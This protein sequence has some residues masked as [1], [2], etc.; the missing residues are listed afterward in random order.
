MRFKT[1]IKSGGSLFTDLNGHTIQQHKYKDKLKIQGNFFPMPSTAFIQDSETRFS[2]LSSEPHGVASL[3]EGYLEVVLDRRNQ[4]D[5]GRGLGQGL[6]D[7]VPTPARLRLLVEFGPGAKVEDYVV[8][9]P[10][11]LSYWVQ[12]SLM[13]PVFAGHKPGD[14]SST[15][16]VQ[17]MKSLPCDEELVN[18]RLVDEEADTSLLIIRNL[19]FTCQMD[20]SQYCQNHKSKPLKDVFTVPV[21]CKAHPLS[22][23]HEFGDNKVQNHKPMQFSS[24]YVHFIGSD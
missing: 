4:K 3:K 5:D 2:V 22:P 24:Y 9:Y 15:R 12:Q 18:L 14:S 6:D 21:E 11:L 16:F 19:G 10:S 1:D 17:L 23:F 13:H 7:N 20:Y 8:E